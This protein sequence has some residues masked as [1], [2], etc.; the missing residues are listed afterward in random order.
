MKRAVIIPTVFLWLLG[1][2]SISLHSAEKSAADL[3]KE[4]A[5]ESSPKKR[6]KVAVDLA[7]QRLKQLSSA[8]KDGEAP[9]QTAASD[10]YCDALDRIDK[11]VVEASSA[12]TSKGAEVQLGI[13]LRQLEELKMNISALDRHGLEKAIGRAAQLRERVLYS[14][15]NPPRESAK[16]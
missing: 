6:V 5:R 3:E 8:F 12:G 16:K 4:Y 1:F 11:A 15:M 7:K 9:Q 13:Q 2:G 10:N 14:I